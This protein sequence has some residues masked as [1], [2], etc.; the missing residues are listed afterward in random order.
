M[1]AGVVRRTQ[2]PPLEELELE[3][4]GPVLRSRREEVEAVEIT[5]A[6]I[7][8]KKDTLPPTARSL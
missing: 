2:P 3:E 5:S 6:G 7:A 4:T 8:S 1:M